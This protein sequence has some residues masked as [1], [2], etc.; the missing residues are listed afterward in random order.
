M[1]NTTDSRLTPE[2]LFSDPPLL[3]ALPA[4]ASFGA[5][6]HGDHEFVVYLQSSAEDREQLELWRSDHGSGP[7][8]WLKAS[9]LETGSLGRVA[10]TEAERAERERKRQFTSGITSYQISQDGKRL[11]VPHGGRGYVFEVAAT[12]GAPIY[13]T[14]AGL[15]QTDLQLSP[16]A[17]WL[18]LVRSGDLYLVNIASGQEQRL[19]QDGSETISN[20]SAD[21]IAAEEMHRFT[22]HWWS[23][24]E[25]SIAFQRTDSGPVKLTHRH[26]IKAAE[27]ELIPQRYPYTGEANAEVKLG[28]YQLDGAMFLCLDFS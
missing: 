12:L 7:Y 5:A 28:L 4:Q 27:I 13:A 25:T 23:P 3:P 14:P 17:Q 15:R 9:D 10:E 22:G 26:D 19:T 2:R 8:C 24:D 20:G 1:T 21:F 6:V 11:L 16:T 18:S